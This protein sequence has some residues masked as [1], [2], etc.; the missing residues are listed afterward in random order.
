LQD[1]A[2]DHSPGG[3][4]MLVPAAPHATA[5]KVIPMII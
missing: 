2:E 1:S 5:A 3:Y 4:G